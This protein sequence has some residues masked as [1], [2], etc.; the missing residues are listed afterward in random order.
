VRIFACIIIV[1]VVI[2]CVGCQQIH[3]EGA[4]LALISSPSVTQLPASP[5]Q[6]IKTPGR[7]DLTMTKIPERVPPTMVITPVTGEVPTKLL[8]SILEDLSERTGAAVENISV[9]QAQ[10]VVWND[11]SLGCPQPGVMYT[12]ALVPGFQVVLEA[13]GQRYDYHASE[14]SYFALCVSGI[15][16]KF[17]SGTPKS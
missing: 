5:I 11:G 2:L 10:A 15:S 3:L 4:P 6:A 1:L 14:T 16:P 7:I 8:D 9:I 13:D 17:P 12:Q